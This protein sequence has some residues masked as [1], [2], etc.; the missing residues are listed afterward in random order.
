LQIFKPEVVIDWLE[1]SEPSFGFSRPID[2]LAIEGS[3]R[4]LEVL[5]RI[6]A[7]AYA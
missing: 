1:G 7:G 4:L 2:V 3:P 6:E 5:D